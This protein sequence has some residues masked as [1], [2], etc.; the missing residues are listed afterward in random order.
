MKKALIT[1]VCGQDGAYLA[2]HLI[3]LGYEVHGGRRRSSLDEGYRLRVL[4]VEDDVKLLNVELTDPYNVMDVVKSGQYDEIYNLAAQSFVG[5]SWELPIQT[6]QVDAMGPLLLLDAIKRTSPHTRFYQASTSE[7]FGLIQEPIQSEKTPFYPRSPYGVAKLFAHSMTVNYRESFG[8]HASSGILFNHESPLRGQDFITKKVSYQ[9]SRVKFGLQDTVKLGNI[10]AKR[11]W[12]YAKEY[13]EGMHLMLQKD[14]GDD[15]V[16]ATGQTT[17]V[18]AFV[19]FVAEGLDYEIEW[20]G[21]GI[22]EKGH[23]KSTGK[24]LIEIDSQFYRPA[25]VDVL[26]GNAEKAHTALGWRAMTSTTEL[27]QLMVKYD[28][29]SIC[30]SQ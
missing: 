3:Q 9:L 7:M 4:G 14:T 2:Q 12:G 1:G 6:S 25:E 8:L 13:V 21:E 19:E 16:L 29:D 5:A 10:Y 11:D 23:D 26:L 27:A 30:K 22:S 17:T 24:L 20:S 18:K 15:Y 28:Y